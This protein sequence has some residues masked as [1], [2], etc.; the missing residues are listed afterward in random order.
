MS[1]SLSDK[2]SPAGWIKP[3]PFNGSSEPCSLASV[4]AR[5]PPV[6]KPRS[7]RLRGC[8]WSTSALT[9]LHAFGILTGSSANAPDGTGSGNPGRQWPPH[10][11]MSTT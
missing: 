6:E 3:M 7:T 5:W 8:R 2:Q 1:K 9:S 11:G 4:Y 10:V